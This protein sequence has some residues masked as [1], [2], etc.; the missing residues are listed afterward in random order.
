MRQQLTTSSLTEF[1]GGKLAA[2]FDKLLMAAGRDCFDRPG[3]DAKRK[4]TLSV[5]LTPELDQDGMCEHVKIEANVGAKTPN[6]GSRKVLANIQKSGAVVFDDL[7]P[8]NPN[9]ET[10]QFDGE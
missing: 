7:S 6:Y 1:E 9:Q 5:E 4:I 3:V 10:F 8:D 2:A